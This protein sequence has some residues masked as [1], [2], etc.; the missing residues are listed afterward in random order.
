MNNLNYPEAYRSASEFEEYIESLQT[1]L[2]RPLTHEEI[3]QAG[4]MWDEMNYNY[5]N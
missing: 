1:D 3:E 5:A 2:E 4:I